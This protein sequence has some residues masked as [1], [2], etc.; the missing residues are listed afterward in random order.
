MRPL[1]TK[2]IR[3]GIRIKASPEIARD[4][5]E[6]V[7]CLLDV[8]R[9]V[10]IQA[11]IAEAQCRAK[12]VRIKAQGDKAYRGKSL[13]VYK[14]YLVALGEVDG[15]EARAVESIKKKFFLLSVDARLM[16]AAGKRFSKR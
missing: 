4:L 7:D 6:V 16:I 9:E 5:L 10:R 13:A 15:D 12:N 1:E 8:L 3:G 11:D 2:R 14:S